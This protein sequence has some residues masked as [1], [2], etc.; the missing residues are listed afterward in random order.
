MAQKQERVDTANPDELLLAVWFIQQLA[1]DESSFSLIGMIYYLNGI[2]PG[3]TKF[4]SFCKRMLTLIN[5]Q[6]QKEVFII[7][8]LVS[9]IWCCLE[10]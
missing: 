1:Q 3:F 7:L 6:K 5:I 4:F 10:I 2:F 9:L 8:T